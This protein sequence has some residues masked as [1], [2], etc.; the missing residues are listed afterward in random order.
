MKNSA[1]IIVSVSGY[2]LLAGAGAWLTDIGPWYRNLKKP[3]WQPPNFLF[4]SVWTII[5]C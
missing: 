4:G 3:S 1:A 2:V 5:V